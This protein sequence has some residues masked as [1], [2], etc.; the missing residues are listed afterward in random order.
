MLGKNSDQ[1]K[2]ACMLIQFSSTDV[3]LMAPRAKQ[4]PSSQSFLYHCSFSFSALHR[5]FVTNS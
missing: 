5:L 1:I 3:K 4:T 2:T